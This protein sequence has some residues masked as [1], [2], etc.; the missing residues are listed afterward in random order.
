MKLKNVL[1]LM[2]AMLVLTL[3][4]FGQK[5]TYKVNDMTDQYSYTF[6]TS[7]DSIACYVS[8]DNR[9]GFYLV[10]SFRENLGKKLSTSLTFNTLYVSF[11]IK[12][13]DCVENGNLI[14]KFTDGTKIILNSFNDFNCKGYFFFSVLPKQKLIL[15]S[16]T[17]DK[18][19]L[20]DNRSGL[21]YTF[22][23]DNPKF[24]I[25]LNSA[26]GMPYTKSTE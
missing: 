26:I 1:F 16:T 5:I 2:S 13:M 25:E 14:I 23:P 7:I 19:M 22:S 4:S 15:S 20:N 8:E 10:P 21:T 24:F 17:I 6:H 11:A 18:I 12:G 9:T 3:S